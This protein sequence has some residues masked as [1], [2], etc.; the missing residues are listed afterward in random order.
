VDYELPMQPITI[1]RNALGTEFGG[2]G[3]SIDHDK[4]KES[5]NFWTRHVA[6]K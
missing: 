1:M 5:V 3:V 2:S 4:Y 6:I